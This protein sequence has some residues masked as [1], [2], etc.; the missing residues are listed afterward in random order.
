[1]PMNIIKFCSW[2][3]KSELALCLPCNS[4][5]HVSVSYLPYLLSNLLNSTCNSWRFLFLP[6]ETYH[7]TL[8][9]Y[10][11]EPPD[12][13]PG[14]S[15]ST[16]LQQ[17]RTRVCPTSCITSRVVLVTLGGFCFTPRDLSTDASLLQ[18]S[19]LWRPIRQVFLDF[20]TRKCSLST[21]VLYIG[22]L[23]TYKATVLISRSTLYKSLILRLHFILNNNVRMCILVI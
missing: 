19:S 21:N 1:M 8:H 18:S 11:A 13:Q 17:Y 9:S 14:R 3:P 5:E 4:K 10:R 22:L 6:Q 16:S 15:S 2:I 23:V 12:V 7:L 20:H